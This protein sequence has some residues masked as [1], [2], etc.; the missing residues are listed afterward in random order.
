MSNENEKEKIEVIENKE[1]VTIDD[2]K[3]KFRH[4]MIV[5][6]LLVVVLIGFTLILVWCLRLSINNYNE[7]LTA[8]TE[9]VVGEMVYCK[10]YER[11]Y[12][13][14]DRKYTEIRYDCAFEFMYNGEKYTVKGDFKKQPEWYLT[15]DIDKNNL[16]KAY[17]KGI[18]YARE[19]AE[20]TMNYTIRVIIGSLIFLSM[21]YLSAIHGFKKITKKYKLNKEKLL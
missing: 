10:P 3:K 15:F 18:E 20:A 6:S 19:E 17:F 9:T 14:N 2:I 13:R 12:T 7:T 5:N 21:F 4:D 8:E 16:E 1:E 11:R